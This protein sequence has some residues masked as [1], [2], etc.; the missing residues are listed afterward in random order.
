MQ[1]VSTTDTA[2][3]IRKALKEAFPGVK[4]SVKSDSYAGG[5][6]IRVKWTDGPSAAMVESVACTFKGSYFDGMT[7][8]KGNVYALM[9]GKLTSFGP[10]FVFCNRED[11]DA[12]VARAIAQLTRFWGAEKCA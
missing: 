3:L 8:C 5:S 2:K 7:D 11:S 10:D 6:S 12:A 9:D 4:F 1:Y